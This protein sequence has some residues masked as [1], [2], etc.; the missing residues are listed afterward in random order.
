MIIGFMVENH[1]MSPTRLAIFYLGAGVLGN[2]FSVCVESEVSV[3]PMTAIMALISGLLASV[4]VNW[5][6]LKGAGMMRICLI[7]MMVFLFVILLLISALGNAGIAWLSISMAGE[8]GGFMAGL[9]LGMMLMPHALQRPSPWVK[10]IRKVGLG[11][12]FIYCV[13]LIPVFWASVEPYK[14]KWAV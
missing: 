8:G 7:F 6:A 14:T 10:T 9:F 13:I 11:L 3:G 1:K 12:T 2:L 4:I 5:G